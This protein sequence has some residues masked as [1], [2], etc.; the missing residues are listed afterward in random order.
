MRDPSYG[1]SLLPAATVL[2]GFVGLSLL[3]VLWLQRVRGLSARKWVPNSTR[4]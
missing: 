2:F 3:E 1:A 4:N